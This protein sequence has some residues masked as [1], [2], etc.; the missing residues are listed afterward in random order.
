MNEWNKLS[1]TD[2]AAYIKLGI[3]NGITDLA[4]I[5]D[6]YNKYAEGGKKDSQN[7][8]ESIESKV[9]TAIMNLIHRGKLKPSNYPAPDLVRD[10][11]VPQRTYLLGREEQRKEFLNAGYI[12]GKEGDYG[13]VRKAVGDRNIPIYQRE[14]DAAK[15]EDLV[16]IGNIDSMYYPKK[17]K[18]I[19][20]GHYPTALYYN[21]Q[22]N[23]LYQKAWDL[24][25]YGG[26]T[27]YAKK[28]NFL[29]KLG[30]N[31]LDKIGSPTVVTSGFQEIPED[32]FYYNQ[33]E[34][35]PYLKNFYKSKGLEYDFLVDPYKDTPTPHLPEI[36]V[37]N[38]SKKYAEG[39][40]TDNDTN[41]DDTYFGLT[42]DDWKDVGLGVL[43]VVGTYRDLQTFYKDPT[44]VNGLGLGISA[45]TDAA[46]LLGVGALA[47][48]SKA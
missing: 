33:N 32:V 24:N 11:G 3:D 38:K 9:S 30:V 26:N 20:A 35:F 41:E 34:L 43:P 25:D 23:K 12:E 19:H 22:D 10:G 4:T 13:L 7:K 16:P 14:P 27:G 17:G 29:Q 28:Y 39:G 36:V 5:R 46:T 1:M 8:S 47:K 31:I 18:L 45:A 44:L 2:R 6:T 40:P 15:R 42:A 21:Y 37:T 48:G